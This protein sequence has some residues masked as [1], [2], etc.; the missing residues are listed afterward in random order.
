MRSCRIRAAAGAAAV[1]VLVPL[2]ACS[3]E[4]PA[5]ASTGASGQAEKVI[6]ITA[7]PVVAEDVQRSVEMV[8]TLLAQDEVTVSNENPG[9]VARIMVDLG[10]RVRKGDFL[11]LLDQREAKL[12]VERAEASLAAARK[13]LDRD[14]AVV[15]WNRANI[16]RARSVQ[17]D[18]RINARRYQE[19][20]AEGAVS[21]SQRDSAQTAADVAAASLRAAEVELERDREA[22]RNAEANVEQ[23]KAAVELARKRLADTEVRAPMA[24]AVKKRLVALGESFKE[25][26]PLF[27]L[28]STDPLKMAGT[29]P[30]RFA[31]E[32]RPGQPVQV[33]V[34]AFADRTFPGRVTRV[35]P[36]VDAET[37]SL[38]LEAEV[39]NREGLLRP[40]FFAKA[41]ILTRVDPGVPFAPEEAIFFFVGITK[42]FVVRDGT[43]EERQTRTGLR[44]DGKVELLEGV[45]P[46]ELVATSSLNLLSSGVRVSVARA[47]GATQ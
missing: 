47:A 7:A 1:L 41:A 40:G 44:R 19:L 33:R 23:A 12:E 4:K 21:A 36:A 26:T 16:D 46:G 30:E 6:P 29:V 15:E 18:A 8:G 42:V 9:T 34:E 22:A 17:E 35:S 11:L 31:P 43:V 38:A 27:I 45:R 14:L 5:R 10:D 24:G 37:R 3:R 2:V 28:V 39:P 13:A 32:I 20:Y 25:K